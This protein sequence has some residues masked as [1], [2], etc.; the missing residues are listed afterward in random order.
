MRVVFALEAETGLERI[1]DYIA[2]D[3]PTRAASFV[4][5]LRDRALS[6]AHSPRAFPLIPRYE[7]S[8]IRR[9]VHGQYLIL[10]RADPDKIVILHV[11]HGAQDYGRLLSPED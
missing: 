1:G 3:N 4:E 6:L 5:E 9:R 8:G 10:Y 11:V 2:Q 7:A